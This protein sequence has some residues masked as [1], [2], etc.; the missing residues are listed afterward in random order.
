MRQPSIDPMMIEAQRQQIIINTRLTALQAAQ[1]LMGTPGYLGIPGSNSETKEPVWVEKPGAVNH[2]VLLAI[3]AD[4]EAYIVAGLEAYKPKSGIVL[5][6][7]MPPPG[8][9]KPGD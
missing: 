5:Q 6:T 3:A 7:Q 9:F 8:T 1:T 2:I 4:I